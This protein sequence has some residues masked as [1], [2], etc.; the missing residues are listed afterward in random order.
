[1]FSGSLDI[2]ERLVPCVQH[3]MSSID[4]AVASI[5]LMFALCNP[6]RFF[7]QKV[8][9]LISSSL[10]QIPSQNIVDK[11]LFLL[12]QRG[13]SVYDFREHVEAV[14]SDYV[15]STGYLDSVDDQ[16]ELGVRDVYSDL[17]M[18]LV[19]IR[20]QS[21]WNSLFL[22]DV[23]ELDLTVLGGGG[24]PAYYYRQQVVSLPPASIQVPSD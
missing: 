15:L 19:Q 3:E 12:D 23:I 22:S 20:F 16:L 13:R 5:Q 7:C 6:Y 2:S 8:F 9:D 24:D 4:L 21:E 17:C 11:R 18:V 10:P 1:M 14:C